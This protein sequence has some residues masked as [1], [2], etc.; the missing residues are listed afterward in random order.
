[1]QQG[2][3]SRSGSLSTRKKAKRPEKRRLVMSG[4]HRFLIRLCRKRAMAGGLQAPD[5]VLQM[6]D[7]ANDLLDL[8]IVEMPHAVDDLVEVEGLDE[9]ARGATRLRQGDVD[10]PAV[11]PVHL[12]LDEAALLEAGQCAG[13]DTGSNA[14]KAGERS[15]G[16]LVRRYGLVPQGPEDSELTKAELSP[17]RN[18]IADVDRPAAV[19]RQHRDHF[20]GE[21]SPL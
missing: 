13:H 19:A 6:S 16:E 18:D 21:V 9:L 8:L 10:P 14:M 2:Q 20:Q 4:K 12:A 3:I 11:M 1:I 17:G 5:D 7:G 15:W